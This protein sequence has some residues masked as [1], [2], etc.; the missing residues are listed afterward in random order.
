[1]AAAIGTLAARRG[2][3]VEVISRNPANAQALA[4]H[5]GAGARAGSLRLHA[6]DAGAHTLEHL[7][8]LSLGLIA[9]PLHHTR[10]ALGVSHTTFDKE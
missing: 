8:L 7:C 5:I 2:H 4:G 3:D 10:F 6:M 1:M 9:R